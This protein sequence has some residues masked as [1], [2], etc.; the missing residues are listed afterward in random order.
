MANKYEP[1][2]SEEKIQLFWKKN[3]YF[4]ESNIGNKTFSML[5]PPPNITGKLHLG[6]AWDAYYPDMLIRYKQMNN[7]EAIWNPGMDHAGIATQIKVEEELLKTEGKNK[8][9]LGR[10]KFI[11]KIWEWKNLY[12]DNI[13]RQWDKLGIALDYKKN[14]FTLDK[15]VND[16]IINT[17]VSLYKKNLIYKGERLINWDPVLKTAISNIEINHIEKNSFIYDIKYK[18]EDSNDFVIISTTRPETIFGDTAVFVN[19]NDDRHKHMIGKFLINPLTGN[20]IKIYTDK[21]V[22]INFGTGILKVTPGHDFNDYKLYKKYNLELINIMNK[23]ASLNDLCGIWKGM[24]RFKARKSILKYLEE[25][26]LLVEKREHIMQIGISERSGTI[27]EPLISEQWFLKSSILAKKAIKAQ[28]I[29]ETKIDFIPKR[30]EQEYIGWLDNMEDWCLS[31]QLWWGHRIPAW[32]KDGKLIVQKDLPGIGWKQDEDVLDTWFSSSLWPIVF[33]DEEII[34]KSDNK[35]YLSDSLFTG[36]DI[37]LF[38][39][40]R[41]IFQSLEIKRK[42]PFQKVIIHGLIRD[43]KGK[44]MSKSLGNGIDPILLIEKW[45]SDSLRLFL[46]GNSTPGKDIKFNETKI[47]SSWDLNNKLFNSANLLR[48]LSNDMK[49][50]RIEIDSLKL[51]IIDNYILKKI[52]EFK[53]ML[54]LNIER[55]NLSIIF[56]GLQKL[57]FIDFANNYLEFIKQNNNQLQIENAINIF[58]ELLIIIHPLIPFITEDIYKSYKSIIPDLKESILLERMKEI[59]F[60][61]VNDIKYLL[62]AL[63]VARMINSN[64]KFIR[65]SKSFIYIETDDRYNINFVNKYIGYLGSSIS[66]KKEQEYSAIDIFPEV[67]II[68]S[69]F[70]NDEKKKINILKDEINNK[71]KYEL[72]RAKKMLSN[73]KFVEN[74]EIILVNAERKKV[75]F[76]QDSLNLIK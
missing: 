37:I 47:Q 61:E 62:A 1:F 27:I 36:Y 57:I 9:D 14:K 43:S 2:K 72:K 59:K 41:M 71:I 21:Y 69:S 58:I 29:A 8:F 6:H 68:F 44:K 60:N 34:L 74:A 46:L 65:G 25:K 13:E 70:D 26:E 16:L 66:L 55:Y 11:S 33:E 76:Y 56:S 39:V 18:Y 15:D 28:S 5:M 48:I 22:Q 31:R 24:D 20:R 50:N 67:G 4:K 40:S 10:I 19:P 3:N 52:S 7:Y 12:S 51:T 32:Y 49:I 45:G 75:E 73:S 63:K 35:G 64:S 53:D 38:W 17:F 23:D 42:A 30:F 54:D